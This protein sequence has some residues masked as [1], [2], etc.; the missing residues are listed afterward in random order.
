[1]VQS[2]GG[3]TGYQARWVTR[4]VPKLITIRTNGSYI[5]LRFPGRRPMQSDGQINDSPA[6]VGNGNVFHGC[7]KPPELNGTKYPFVVLSAACDPTTRV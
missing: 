2:K 5:P 1:M 7:G 4:C 6:T 3:K